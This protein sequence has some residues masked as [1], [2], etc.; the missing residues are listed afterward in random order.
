MDS[1]SQIDLIEQLADEFA[2]RQQ[3]GEKPSVGE[4][5]EQYPDLASEIREVLPALVMM[6][7]V[8]PLSEDLKEPTSDGRRSLP[9]KTLGDYRI[10]REIG[11]GGMGIVY[12]A[13]Q[14]ALRR[15]VA[16]KV[17]PKQNA[18]DERSLQRFDQEARAAARMHHTNIVPVFDVGQADDWVYYAM[19]LIQGQSLDLVLDD[20][21]RIRSEHQSLNPG[22]TK[23]SKTALNRGAPDAH[24]IA[25]SLAQGKFQSVDLTMAAD[26][27]VDNSSAAESRKTVKSDTE[28]LRGYSETVEQ[29]SGSSV[30]AVLPGEADISTAETNRNDY[31]RSVAQIGLQTARALAYAHSRGIIHRDIKP[32]NL[33]LDAAGTVWV[34]DFGLAKTSDEGMTHTGDILGTIRYMS[35]ERFRGQCDNRAD[36]YSLGLTLY[37]MLALQPAFASPDRLRLIEK[38][39]TTHLPSL[40]TLDDRIPRDLET[41]VLKCGDKDARSRYQSADELCEDLERFIQDEP[42]KARRISLVERVSRWSRHNKGLARSLAVIATLLL[43]INIAGPIL[44]LNLATTKAELADGNK[45]L[46]ATRDELR[47]QQDELLKQTDR[48]K[49]E[50]ARATK[51]E[52]SARRNLYSADM[53]LAR[54]ALAEG[55]L[56]RA[57]ML[58]QRHWPQPGQE[59]LRCWVWR[60]LWQRAQGDQVDTMGPLQTCAFTIDFSPDNTLFVVSDLSGRGS[61]WDLAS[62]QEVATLPGKDVKGTRGAFSPTG[63]YLAISR[64]EG[65]IDLYDWKSGKKL[66]SLKPDFAGYRQIRSLSFSADGTRL[67]VY[68]NYRNRGDSELAVWDL[69]TEAPLFSTRLPTGYVSGHHGV[70]RLSPDGSIVYAGNGKDL[71]AFDVDSGDELFEVNCHADRVTALAVSPDGKRLATGA[72]Y[73][74]TSVKV[75]QA[76]D[77]TYVGQFDGHSGWIPWLEFMPDGK[78]VVSASADHTA[79]IWDSET[80]EERRVLRGHLSEVYSLSI[81]SDGK[82]IVTACK[83]G[84]I[85]LWETSSQIGRTTLVKQRNGSGIQWEGSPGISGNCVFSPDSLSLLTCQPDGVNALDRETFKSPRLLPKTGGALLLSSVQDGRHLLLHSVG[86]TSVFDLE[87]ESIVDRAGPISANYR[88]D[89]QRMGGF[90]GS[91]LS[92]QR[93][94]AI[95]AG[96]QIDY[97][98]TVTW[99]KTKSEELEGASGYGLMAATGNSLAIPKERGR[100][101]LWNRLETGRW[102][103]KVPLQSHRR[104]TT[105]IVFSPDGSL[106]ATSSED[107]NATII[108]VATGEV[109]HNL[110][111]HDSVHSICFSPDGRRVVTGGSRKD[112]VKIWDVA[113]GQEV[114]KIESEN[115]LFRSVCFSPDGNSIAARSSGRLYHLWH[116]PP[117]DQIE[118]QEYVRKTRIREASSGLTQLSQEAREVQR[119]FTQSFSEDL[120]ELPGGAEPSASP[121]VD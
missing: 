32:A 47:K 104:R 62:R 22:T 45:R 93:T 38:V 23:N 35:P 21:K 11:R 6:E 24:S 36:I 97:W 42:I 48:A 107:G 109:I 66:R 115:S 79:R 8:V 119:R 25:A 30:S 100:L 50:A 39:T 88:S 71:L 92:D 103:R 37:E 113:N 83:D 82:S 117:M 17:L 96:S 3:R 110:R 68:R 1:S 118:Q 67:C 106:L 108:E 2:E 18:S 85:N 34:T 9:L 44:T 95:V 14:Q 65:R 73:S 12:E 54:H 20:L 69:H 59:D 43:A 55:N 15:R 114:F 27:A 4:Y 13:E 58:L 99:Q 101:E 98:D 41:I 61:L 53:N 40:R 74:E 90:E 28:A 70:A 112:A 78:S 87:T 31:F 49:R 77:G 10:I 16:L 111:G 56:G 51:N 29:Q 105:G 33:L 76:D 19:Q 120:D 72:G 52:E 80:F 63:N 102:Q 64:Y 94:F 26:A 60:H 91:L 75:W 7:Q 46:I 84:K 121:E 86:R 89:L 57:S 81:S 5:I 116:A